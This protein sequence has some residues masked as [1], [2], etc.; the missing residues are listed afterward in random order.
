M[1]HNKYISYI[2]LSGT[3]SWSA[4]FVVFNKLSPYKNTQL[5]FL[6]FFLT[7]F[8]ALSCTFTVLGFYFRVWLF[9]NEIF[10]KHI[11]IAFR[12]G[13]F[14]SLITIFTLVFQ[15]IDILFWWSGVLLILIAVMMEFYFS[16]RDS[17]IL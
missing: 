14:L 15:I 6:F 13:V 5:A 7:L 2:A 1:T 17:E 10:Y 3:L 12:Q 4:W 9:K 16:S 8:I 11:N